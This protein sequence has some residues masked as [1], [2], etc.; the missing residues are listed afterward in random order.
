MNVVFRRKGEK[1]R[2][3]FGF[4][5]LHLVFHCI[6]LFFSLNSSQF[7]IRSDDRFSFD[8]K[9][10]FPDML[11]ALVSDI[12]SPIVRIS[13][14]VKSKE[15]SVCF[16]FVLFSKWKLHG[17]Y[18]GLVEITTLP[19]LVDKFSV[20]SSLREKIW[21]PSNDDC[22]FYS[23]CLCISVRFVAG[24]RIGS[25]FPFGG[26]LS[27]IFPS[28]GGTFLFSSYVSFCPLF[29]RFDTWTFHFALILSLSLVSHSFKRFV[30]VTDFLVAF[31]LDIHFFLLILPNTFLYIT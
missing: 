2:D 16:I 12:L 25:F 21:Y 3:Y 4:F 18:S 27:S 30:C 26:S 29:V 13:R 7:I 24:W 8:E 20:M 17:I 1:R 14:A 11:S 22:E 9:S 10:S 28:F 5:F 31:M 23:F 19:K 6:V 15:A